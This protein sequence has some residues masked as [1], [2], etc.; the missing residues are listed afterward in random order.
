M[1]QEVESMNMI[2]N[3]KV[4]AARQVFRAPIAG[5]ALCAGAFLLLAAG[6]LTAQRPFTPPRPASPPRATPRAGPQQGP[7][8]AEQQRKRRQRDEEEKLRRGSGSG[9]SSAPGGDAKKPDPDEEKPELAP[10][11][12]R[13]GIRA[14]EAWKSAQKLW[15]DAS[16][17][18]RWSGV[19]TSGRKQDVD[20]ELHWR[21]EAGAWSIILVT[22]RRG[23]LPPLVHLGRGAA[24][25]DLR[26]ITLTP[27]ESSLSSQTTEPP[28][29]LAESG[30]RITDLLP[31]D[32]EAYDTV[33]VDEDVKAGG[34]R[35]FA[36]RLSAEKEGAGA[37][38]ARVVVREDTPIASIIELRSI[39]GRVQRK[40]T[41]SEI[42]SS[43]VHR[44]AK[45]WI[46]RDEVGGNTI[47]VKLGSAK[48]NRGLEPTMFEARNLGELAKPKEAVKPSGPERRDGVD[49]AEGS[50][51]RR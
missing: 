21:R 18:G 13:A 38:N 39:S 24:T 46:V 36:V 8:P 5:L 20:F 16:L 10:A 51:K 44:L 50:E 15:K 34:A 43:G 9:G 26:W 42:M 45:E 1:E 29:V 31:F 28:R 37:P 14:Y 22:A 30:L 12:V 49:K 35:A 25:S 33:L 40:L 23:D 17:A 47:R 3:A 2:Q 19:S 41:T 11:V 7:T 48:I 4:G 32:C 6:S 27:E